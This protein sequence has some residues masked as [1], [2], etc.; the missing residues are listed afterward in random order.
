M[1]EARR[2]ALRAA[3]AVTLGVASAAGCDAVPMQRLKDPCDG[4]PFIYRDTDGCA[5]VTAGDM[6]EDKWFE[7]GICTYGRPVPGPFVPPKMII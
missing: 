4:V 7:P 2:K 3:M 6:W 1:T 5:C